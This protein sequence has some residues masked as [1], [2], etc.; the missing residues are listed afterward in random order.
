[1]NQLIAQTLDGEKY[2]NINF[3]PFLNTNSEVNDLTN[4][5]DIDLSG[6]SGA[7]GWNLP[8][9]NATCLGKWSIVLN[10]TSH[11]DWA[12]KK[13]CILV[14]PEGKES[15]VDGLFFKPDQPFNQGSIYSLSDTA[16]NKALDISLQKA[17]TKNAEG[18]KLRKK[19][20]YSKTL[21][22]IISKIDVI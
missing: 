3:L 7:E 6:L 15:A 9:F 20:S 21:S 19:F 14:E 5:I 18:V 11:K 8:S 17:K 13:N 10:A 1:M 22:S 12:T 2:G 16:I 4:S